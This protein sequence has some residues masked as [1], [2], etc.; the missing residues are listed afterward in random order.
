MTLVNLIDLCI[1]GTPPRHSKTSGYFITSSVMTRFSRP[2]DRMHQ[3]IGCSGTL[4]SFDL[5]LLNQHDININKEEIK[6]MAKTRNRKAMNKY[7]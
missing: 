5:M 4:Q 1:C 7:L 6:G 2:A 3:R